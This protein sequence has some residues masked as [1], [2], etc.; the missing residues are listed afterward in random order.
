MLVLFVNHGKEKKKMKWFKHLTASGSDPDIGELIDELGFEGYYLFFRT[1]EIMSIEFNINNPGQNLFNFDW[2]LNQF[3]RKIS[4]K[5]LIN[6]LEITNKKGRILY[7]LNG[8]GIHL[9]CPKL[10]NLTDEYTRQKPYRVKEK[11]TSKVTGKVTPK[12]KDIRLKSINIHKEIRHEVI[13]YLN[14]KTGKSFH[15]DADD[16]IKFINGRLNDNKNPATKEDLLRVIDV[17]VFQWLDDPDHDKYLR[18]ET[19]FNKTK[20]EGY[21]NERNIK[22]KEK[23]ITFERFSEK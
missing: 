20:F 1:I 19:L 17:K 5:K 9:N 15:P 14:E 23:Q 21:R 18:P 4:R 16:A 13:Q 12:I 11:V 10:K 6:F 8:S 22:P 3:S 2:F 7:S